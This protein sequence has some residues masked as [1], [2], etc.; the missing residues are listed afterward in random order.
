L[1][2][3]VF[4]TGSFHVAAAQD[5]GS[6]ASDVIIIFD[7]SSSMGDGHRYRGVDTT[8]FNAAREKI[9]EA[10]ARLAGG[11]INVGV[12]AFKNE[13]SYLVRDLKPL[14]N[15]QEIKDLLASMQAE[16]GTPLAKTILYAKDMLKASKGRHKTLMIFSDGQ[17]NGGPQALAAAIQEFNK[18]LNAD[19]RIELFAMAASVDLWTQFRDLR[20]IIYHG[21]LY[22]WVSGQDQ[23]IDP[24]FNLTYD[25]IKGQWP[26]DV[27]NNRVRDALKNL[28]NLHADEVQILDA[29]N[30]PRAYSNSLKKEKLNI[31]WAKM[32]KD[33]PALYAT[34]RKRVEGIESAY[35]QM[36]AQ[37]STLFWVGFQMNNLSKDGQ[38]GF[39]NLYKTFIDQFIKE[40][41]AGSSLRPSVSTA[42]SAGSAASSAAPYFIIDGLVQSVAMATGKPIP[43]IHNYLYERAR[44][45]QESTQLAGVSGLLSLTIATAPVTMV[46]EQQI[47][48]KEIPHYL[49][50]AKSSAGL[51]SILMAGSSVTFG[52]VGLKGAE[53]QIQRREGQERE[54]Q[55]QFL[56]LERAR[57]ELQMIFPELSEQQVRA[58]LARL[59]QNGLSDEDRLAI[60]FDH[61]ESYAGLVEGFHQLGN[62]LVEIERATPKANSLNL[63]RG[64]EEL[65]NTIEAHFDS[66]LEK[67]REAYNSLSSELAKRRDSDKP[68]DKFLFAR[69]V[70]LSKRFDNL[71]KS[72]LTLLRDLK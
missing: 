25:S 61:D 38:P 12:L 9:N 56:S 41:Q 45:Y 21:T 15:S 60:F 46:F 71:E 67:S 11:N 28:P 23:N 34:L 65:P 66:L 10:A 39:S 2:L 40:Q 30:S 20:D 16:G 6:Q 27:H 72:M 33:N 42:S 22:L 37:A 58:K 59:T 4:L 47:P 32:K 26:N 18:E 24:M 14:S 55:A 64:Q 68:A 52:A 63:V 19:V 51:G 13:E 62:T 31:D 70:D 53:S 57:A 17:D 49:R 69:L 50:M 36:R 48:K 3:S 8:R 54:L 1:L 29:G 44:R 7:T 35:L 43:Y 5:F